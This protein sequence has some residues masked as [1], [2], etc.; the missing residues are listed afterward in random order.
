[1]KASSSRQAFVARGL[2]S[3]QD[4]METNTMTTVKTAEF[5]RRADAAEHALCLRFNGACSRP[6][7]RGLFVAV[8]RLG[9]GIFWYLLLLLLPLIYGEAALKPAVRMAGVGVIGVL[10]YKCLK[11]RLVRERPYISLHG[12]VAGTAPL[13]RYSFPSGHTLHASSF[14]ILAV[15]AFPALGWVLVP[16]ALLVAASRLVLGLHYP[17]DV[18]AG[19]LIGGGLALVGILVMPVSG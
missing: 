1:M 13:D 12:I 18:A 17:T 10:L 14:T 5:F 2:H 3:A 9:D 8:S 19:A 15:T 7:V 11:S 4:T 16:F 6:R